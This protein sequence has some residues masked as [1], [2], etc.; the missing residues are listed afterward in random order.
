MT[1]N[2]M[3]ERHSLIP[4]YVHIYTHTHIICLFNGNPFLSNTK[5]QAGRELET[6][7][8]WIFP[9]QVKKKKKLSEINKEVLESCYHWNN[10]S[11]FY[12]EALRL[13]VVRL[14]LWPNSWLMIEHCLAALGLYWALWALMLGCDWQMW[15]VNVRIPQQDDFTSTLTFSV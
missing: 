11:K 3:F 1:A 5:N 9:F 10:F 15:P 14:G 8:T 7:W 6:I 2:V 4:P 13:R 12:L